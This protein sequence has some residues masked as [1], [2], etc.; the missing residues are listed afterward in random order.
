[1]NRKLGLFSLALTLISAGAYA[2]S[3]ESIEAIVSHLSDSSKNEFTKSLF[4]FSLAALIHS[5]RMKKEIRANF[6]MLVTSI[7]NVSTALKEDLAKQ[8][9]ILSSHGD[10]LDGLTNRVGQLEST[11]KKGE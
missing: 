4:I 7:D 9:K 6:E 1:M 8:S 5:G 2:F 3:P 10:R 11:L